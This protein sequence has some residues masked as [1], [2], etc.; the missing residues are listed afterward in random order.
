MRSIRFGPTNYF[1]IDDEEPSDRNNVRR[2]SLQRAA[3]P[4]TT[5][6]GTEPDHLGP[7]NSNRA[8]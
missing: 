8:E 3:S 2:S 1:D 6:P 7:F 5:S 4:T